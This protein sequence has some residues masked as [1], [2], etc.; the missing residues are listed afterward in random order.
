MSNQKTIRV[1]VLN[2]EDKTIEER[3]LPKENL[4]PQLYDIIG[5]NCEIVQSYVGFA[6]E[7]D[8]LRNSL[9]GDEEILLR[10]DDIQG[11]VRILDQV[12]FC[13]IC[14]WVGDDGENFIDSDLDLELVKETTSFLTKEEAIAHRNEIMTN[15][16]SLWKFY[17]LS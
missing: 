1:I 16:N 4:L 12:N 7:D 13:N 3:Y 2:P 10:P 9:Y 11:G 15:N 5:N 8:Q 17:P 6:G 14:V